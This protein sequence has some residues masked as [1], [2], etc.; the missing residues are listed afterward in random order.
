MLKDKIKIFSI[1]FLAIILVV[2]SNTL[3]FAEEGDG[4]P[5]LAINLVASNSTTDSECKIT[6][7]KA[8]PVGFNPDQNETTKISFTIN[9]DLLIELNILDSSKNK[10]VNIIDDEEKSAKDHE[11]TWDGTINNSGGA[12]VDNGTYEYQIIAKNTDS[13]EEVDKVEGDI[14]VIIAAPTTP[15]TPTTP[16]VPTTDDQGTV[17]LQNTATG[18]TAETGPG[19]LIYGVFPV[20]GALYSRRKA[21]KN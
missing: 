4:P 13:K 9:C 5:S 14:N 7:D 16:T 6:E 19:I 17:S 12:Y 2:L 15:T 11:I 1:S 8:E 21:K 20:L 18:T 10:V 3:A